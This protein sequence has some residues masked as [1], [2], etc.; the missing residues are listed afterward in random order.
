MRCSRV[1]CVANDYPRTR[2]YKMS[3]GRF[4]VTLGTF[5]Q[6]TSA[7]WQTLGT[8]HAKSDTTIEYTILE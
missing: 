5:M 8:T 4:V 6:G 2:C 7:N 1:V 3:D